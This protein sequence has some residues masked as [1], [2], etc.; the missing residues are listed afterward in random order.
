M[1]SP[2]KKQQSAKDRTFSP[3]FKYELEVVSE[4]RANRVYTFAISTGGGGDLPDALPTAILPMADLPTDTFAV[5][6]M[7]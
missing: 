2:E 3:A 7:E 1:L 4:I 6:I 5:F